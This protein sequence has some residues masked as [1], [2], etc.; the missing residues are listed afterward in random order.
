VIAV[1]DQGRISSIQPRDTWHTIESGRYLAYCDFEIQRLTPS[2]PQ[3][4]RCE[5]AF[6]C[7]PMVLAPGHKVAGLKW[8]AVDFKRSLSDE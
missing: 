7:G 6:G 5:G 1:V 2:H 4:V 3:Y 8:G